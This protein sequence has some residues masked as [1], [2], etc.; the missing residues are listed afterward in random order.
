MFTCSTKGVPVGYDNCAFFFWLN[1]FFIKYE[2]R[3]ITE[4]LIIWWTQFCWQHKYISSIVLK[5]F[6]NSGTT[7]SWWSAN[8]WTTHT[9]RKLGK[10][11]GKTLAWKSS[12]K[13][14]NERLFHSSIFSTNTKCTTQT[15][16][17]IFLRFIE[18]Y[19]FV[20]WVARICTSVDTRENETSYQDALWVMQDIHMLAIRSKLSLAEQSC[21]SNPSSGSP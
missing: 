16:L 14:R 3:S 18:I 11:G 4:Q 15:N 20:C 5:Y 7:G 12:S 1:T 6:L 9:R 2:Y 8:S 17:W 10:S 21:A 19:I 13:I